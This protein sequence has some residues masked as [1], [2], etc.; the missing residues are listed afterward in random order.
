MTLSK[1]EYIEDLVKEYADMVYR[2]AMSRTRNKDNA[3][4]V[5]QEVFLRLAKNKPKFENKLHEKAWIIR[6]TINCTK[7]ILNSTW[8]KRTTILEDNIL[9]E[10]KKTYDVYY[11]VLKLP[12]K[13][14]TI[15]HLFYYEGFKIKEISILLNMTESTV[16]TRLHR[17]REKL[18]N[19][20]EGG[21]ENE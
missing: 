8:L 6:V 13:Y 2:L 11:E 17:A 19:S 4:D 18:K 12:L 5:F 16:K 9:V 3:E 14:R 20:L 7:N 10:D 21:F 1:E 15:I